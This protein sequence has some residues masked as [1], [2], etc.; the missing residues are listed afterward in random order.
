MP[1]TGFVGT[2]MAKN[3]RRNGIAVPTP[4]EAKSTRQQNYP[5]GKNPRPGLQ[6]NR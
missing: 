3:G 1:G 6:D 2:K 4:T 5:T